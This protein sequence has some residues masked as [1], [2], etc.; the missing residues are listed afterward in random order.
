MHID[1]H[2]YVY[3][4]IYNL[5]EFMQNLL[6]ISD[7]NRDKIKIYVNTGVPDGMWLEAIPYL[8]HGKVQHCTQ[9]K[10]KKNGTKTID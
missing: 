10:K 8:T 4:Y 5:K 3:T 2:T 1:T 9:S 7:I 6:W